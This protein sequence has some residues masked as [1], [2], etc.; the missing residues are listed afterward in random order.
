MSVINYLKA[1]S[2][3]C[4]S[5]ISQKK[6]VVFQRE[7]GLCP[8]LAL[9]GGGFPRK[10][11]GVTRVEVAQRATSTLECFRSWRVIDQLTIYRVPSWQVRLILVQRKTHIDPYFPPRDLTEG[12][13]P[14]SKQKVFVK[15][16]LNSFSYISWLTNTNFHI[17]DISIDSIVS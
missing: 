2:N 12:S 17:Y 15:I 6:A 11:L 13:I 14:D 7:E 8:A 10:R 9:I 3:F 1:M 16:N 4:E 5:T